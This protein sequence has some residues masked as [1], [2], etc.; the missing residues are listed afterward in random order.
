[1]ALFEAAEQELKEIERRKRPLLNGLPVVY[2]GASG[3]RK[4][5]EAVDCPVMLWGP[6]PDM[7]LVD[8]IGLAGGHTG[9]SM[10]GPCVLF[11][12]TPRIGL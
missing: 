11:S 10:A 4:K 3:V 8:E 5:I 6:S 9:A 12:T 7:R 2:Y 1:M